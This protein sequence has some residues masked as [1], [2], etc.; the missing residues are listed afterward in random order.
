MTL[1]KAPAA[2]KISASAKISAPVVSDPV[3]VHA[4]E[5]RRSSKVA[6]EAYKCLGEL[7]MKF[8]SQLELVPGDKQEQAAA[9]A[10]EGVGATA[11]KV[12]PY[13]GPYGTSPAR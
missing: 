3:P 11:A 2:L 1:S 6:D 12:E 4:Q 8:K 7:V 13:A 10:A 5:V 9:G